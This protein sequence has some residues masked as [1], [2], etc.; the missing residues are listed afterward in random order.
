MN[1]Y[2]SR[3]QEVLE[4]LKIGDEVVVSEH[5]SAHF[6]RPSTFA[7]VTKITK[8][9]ITLSNLT[10]YLLSDGEEVGTKGSR[11]GSYIKFENEWGSKPIVLTTRAQAEPRNA[12][13]L[14]ERE[15]RTRR[16]KLNNLFSSFELNTEQVDA[17]A[18]IAG[19]EL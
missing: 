7:T 15:L 3:K 6:A 18:K 14:S 2:K 10:R 1:T 4:N 17:I 13:I 11:Y 12:E 19:V 9:Q 5:N 8:T 16:T